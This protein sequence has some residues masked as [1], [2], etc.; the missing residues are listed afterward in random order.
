[1][2]VVVCCGEEMT[3]E[4]RRQRSSGGSCGRR[5]ER[6]R[7]SWERGERRGEAKENVLSE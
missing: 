5:G 2:V 6:G 3:E 4:A 7:K 1:M